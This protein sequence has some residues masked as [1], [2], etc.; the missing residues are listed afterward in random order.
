MGSQGEILI[1]VSK[2]EERAPKEPP[3]PLLALIV[4]DFKE[5]E[6]CPIK[7]QETNKT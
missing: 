5:K 2:V 6:I 1:S 4:E 3:M 7:E